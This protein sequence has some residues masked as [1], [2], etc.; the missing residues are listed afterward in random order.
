HYFAEG[1]ANILLSPAS[2]DLGGVM[3][4]PLGKDF[5]KIDQNDIRE[6]LNEICISESDSFA[7]VNKIKSVL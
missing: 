1:D 7:I 5:E 2:V 4:T 6:I 3:I